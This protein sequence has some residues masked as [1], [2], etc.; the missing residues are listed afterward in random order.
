MVSAEEKEMP[1]RNKVA[2]QEL[3]AWQ[4]IA[5]PTSSV[6]T[7]TLVGALLIVIGAIIQDSHQ[8]LRATQCRY[9]KNSDL[10]VSECKFQTNDA[11]QNG[12]T[13]N[14][15]IIFTEDMD[16]S[17]GPIHFSYGL[18]NYIQTYRRYVKSI[19]EWQLADKDVDDATETCAPLENFN[20]SLLYPCGLVANSYFNDTFRGFI[21]QNDNNCQLLTGDEWKQT[22]ISWESDRQTKFRARPLR[23]G[24]T[25]VGPNGQLPSIDDEN[26]IVWMR[27]AGLPDFRNLYSTIDRSFS[28]GDQLKI[29]ISNEYPVSSF[30][31]TKT[32][33]LEEV[34]W[35]SGRNNFLGILYL[36]VGSGCLTAACIFVGLQY[37]RP[38]KLAD[39][40][41]IPEEVRT[42]P[43]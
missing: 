29:E 4:P 9:D 17:N 23:S 30:D 40:L 15:T 5:T 37:Y 25:N 31:G 14:V 27:T 41:L 28:K 34:N 3:K 33:I 13:C 20:G 32:L 42:T 21:C 24:E 35:M 6:V 39:P 11:C 10:D 18:T 12:N 19:S 7:L 1:H 38:R 8:K 2:Q 26:F 22:D 16:N 36:L 43:W